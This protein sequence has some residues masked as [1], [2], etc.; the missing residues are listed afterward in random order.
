MDILLCPS[1]ESGV[2][3]LL[4]LVVILVMLVAVGKC[5]PKT[6][7]VGSRETLTLPGGA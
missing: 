5:A 1:I 7:R 3:V 6:R 2:V 4:P